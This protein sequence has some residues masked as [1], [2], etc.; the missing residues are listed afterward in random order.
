[1]GIIE[2]NGLFYIFQPPT[3]R[4]IWYQVE[5]KLNLP[6]KPEAPSRHSNF[7]AWTLN[8]TKHTE[9][10]GE[11]FL[12]SLERTAEGFGLALSTVMLRVFQKVFACGRT[13]HKGEQLPGFK[14]IQR[15]PK[16]NM[17]C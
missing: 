13:R 2:S 11:G 8:Y 3:T 6:V 1:M 16:C 15:A 14:R 17:K 7:V 9:R 10:E 5:S 12:I 4:R